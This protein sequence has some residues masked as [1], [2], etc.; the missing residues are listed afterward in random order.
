MIKFWGNGHGKVNVIDY[1][2]D[3]LNPFFVNERWWDYAF[4]KED[5][6]CLIFNE[7]VVQNVLPT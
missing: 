5:Y 3:S 1:L 6:Q 2:Q 7:V 4:R